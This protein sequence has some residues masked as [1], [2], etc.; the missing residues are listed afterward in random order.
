MWPEHD[1][2]PWCAAFVNHIAWLCGVSRSESLMARSYLEVGYKVHDYRDA[3]VGFSV[4]ILSRGV[5]VQPDATILNAPGHVAFFSGFDSARGH[6]RLLG[7][8]Q[9]NTVK[10][11]SYPQD[12]ILGIRNLDWEV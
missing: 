6:V 8:N 3:Q 5:G 10:I 2:V 4:V 1:E 11:S 9:S 12:R 7:G